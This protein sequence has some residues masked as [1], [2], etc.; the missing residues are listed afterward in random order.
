MIPDG[1]HVPMAQGGERFESSSDGFGRACE[2]IPEG[3]RR[4]ERANVDHLN[5]LHSRSTNFVPGFD[6]SVFGVSPLPVV[7]RWPFTV[8][9]HEHRFCV[10]GRLPSLLQF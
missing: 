1:G 5:S 7:K 6:D 8:A 10:A 4:L 3:W 9:I 2:K